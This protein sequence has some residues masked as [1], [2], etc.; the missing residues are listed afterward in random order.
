MVSFIYFRFLLVWKGTKVHNKQKRMRRNAYM[1]FDKAVQQER[2]EEYEHMLNEWQRANYGKHVAKRVQSSRDWMRPRASQQQSGSG[3]RGGK[4]KG[5]GGRGNEEKIPRGI[6]DRRHLEM[7]DPTAP[8]RLYTQKP[9]KLNTFVPILHH[10]TVAKSRLPREPEKARRSVT[11]EP[12]EYEE[13]HRSRHAK[14]VDP[15]RMHAPNERSMDMSSLSEEVVPAGYNYS[16]YGTNLRHKQKAHQ[17]DFRHATKLLMQQLPALNELEQRN[18]EY[19]EDVDNDVELDTTTFFPLY[20]P[21]YRGRGRKLLAGGTIQKLDGRKRYL[22]E[23]TS[24]AQNN[25]SS[26]KSKRRK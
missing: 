17:S 6:V 20:V 22:A 15:T 5:G 8:S 18:N 10:R 26:S 16:L 1:P 19:D 11:F 2:D 21:N 14:G 4:P 7:E 12:D 25:N 13:H 9:N 24:K 23:L 3:G